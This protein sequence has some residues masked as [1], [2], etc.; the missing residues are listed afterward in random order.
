MEPNNY[1]GIHIISETVVVGGMAMYFYNKISE[2]ENTISNLKDQITMQNNQIRYLISSGSSLQQNCNQF[3]PHTTPLK[4]PQNP[5]IENFESQ[6]I[7]SEKINIVHSSNIQSNH[8]TKQECEG[9]ICRLA[10]QTIQQPI[11]PE[12]KVSI[13]KISKQIKFDRENIVADH[14]SKVQTFVKPSPNPLLKS[15]TPNP[16]TSICES[17]ENL[18]KILQDI[19]NEE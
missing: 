7:P 17:N 2:L 9:G 6:N 12:K 15:V 19:D 14:T 3:L 5:K 10:P 8:Q 4:I 18:D 1:N 13:S 16:S 11:S